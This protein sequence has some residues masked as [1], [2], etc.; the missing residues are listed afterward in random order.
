MIDDY[1][2]QNEDK[3][4]TNPVHHIFNPGRDALPPPQQLE[5]DKS[6]PATIKR[7]DWEEVENP[8]HYAE[9]SSQTRPVEYTGSGCLG[10]CVTDADWA[11]KAKGLLP[12]DGG[13][14][15]IY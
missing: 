12:G 7:R 13:R 15:T 10:S 4:K 14:Y 6:N 3:G 11:H 1:H 8:D 2:E 5:K 9:K